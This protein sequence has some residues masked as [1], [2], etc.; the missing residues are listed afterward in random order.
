MNVTLI[1]DH[2]DGGKQY[3]AGDVIDVDADTAQWLAKQGAIEATLS[4]VVA[5]ATKKTVKE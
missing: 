5:P 2:I 4:P 1:K 3:A